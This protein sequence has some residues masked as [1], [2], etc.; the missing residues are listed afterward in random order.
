MLDSEDGYAL[1][2]GTTYEWMQTPGRGQPVRVLIHED[3]RIHDVRKLLE[4]ALE[5]LDQIFARTNE[6]AVLDQ[7]GE[8][9]F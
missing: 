1:M 6:D 3:A 5:D 2:H 8:I 9:P 4:Y 7:T